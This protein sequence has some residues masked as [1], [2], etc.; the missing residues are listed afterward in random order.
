MRLRLLNQILPNAVLIVPCCPRLTSPLLLIAVGVA[1][2]GST[3]IMHFKENN[4]Q[5]VIGGKTLG[6]KEQVAALGGLCIPL[7]WL[8][9]AGSVVFWLLGMVACRNSCPAHDGRV[10]ITSK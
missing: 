8:A 2:S 6:Y 3:A 9:G 7:F 5:I 10:C 1:I 4:T